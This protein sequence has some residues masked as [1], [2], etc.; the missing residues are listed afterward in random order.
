MTMYWY[1]PFP[2]K[3]NQGVVFVRDDMTI[4]HEEANI[5]IIQQVVS[6]GSANI[7]TVADDTF[8]LLTSLCV[9]PRHHWACHYYFPN[10]GNDRD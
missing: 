7:L 3:I 1:Y 6:V 9:R 10:T 4:T 5:M 8:G 2:I